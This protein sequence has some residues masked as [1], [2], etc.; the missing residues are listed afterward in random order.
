VSAKPHAYYGKQ[1]LAAKGVP[2]AHFLAFAESANTVQDAVLAKG[3]L[4]KYI[5]RQAVVITSDYHLPRAQY[6]FE[7][8]FGATAKLTFMGASSHS[9]AQADLQRYQ[10]HETKA[11]QDLQANGVRY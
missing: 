5:P 3:L 4:K 8:V 11:L 7:H 9:V 10:E 6:I 1:Y 2:D